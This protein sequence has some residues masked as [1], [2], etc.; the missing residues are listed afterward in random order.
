MMQIDE[1][2]LIKYLIQVRSEGMIGVAIAGG[3][4]VGAAILVSLFRK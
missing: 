1:K 4:A 2:V 3:L